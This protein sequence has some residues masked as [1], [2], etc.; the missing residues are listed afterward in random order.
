MI[1]MFSEIFSFDVPLFGEDFLIKSLKYTNIG[2]PWMKQVVC[3]VLYGRKIKLM[4]GL[5]C[6]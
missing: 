1:L 3:V 6:N 4:R 5:T 2:G